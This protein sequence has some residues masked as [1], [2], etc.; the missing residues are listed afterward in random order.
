MSTL[1]PLYLHNLHLVLL[2]LPLVLGNDHQVGVHALEDVLDGVV[3]DTLHVDPPERSHCTSVMRGEEQ[4][5]V[6]ELDN[7]C[8]TTRDHDGVVH[9]ESADMSLGR[10]PGG[11]CAGTGELPQSRE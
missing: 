11:H 3:E 9:V 4:R 2:L 6:P 10:S 8:S 7:P 5:Q 1:V